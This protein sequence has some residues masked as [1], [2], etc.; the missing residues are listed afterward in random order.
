MKG[1]TYFPGDWKTFIDQRLV[2]DISTKE[3]LHIFCLF[4]P[5]KSQVVVKINYSGEDFVLT[6]FFGILVG[7]FLR[8]F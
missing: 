6:I 3:L 5:T 4:F 1:Q 8:S 7:N 2:P